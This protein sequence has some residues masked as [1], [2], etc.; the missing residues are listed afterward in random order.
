MK[1]I[2]LSIQEQVYN[3]NLEFKY[4]NNDESEHILQLLARKFNFDLENRWLWDGNL[5]S[6][7]QSYSNDWEYLLKLELS[8]LSDSIFICPSDDEFYPWPL[9]KGPKD[10]VIELL[11]SLYFFEY[12]IFDERM[13]KVLFDTHH[14]T[15][16]V[17]N[18]ENR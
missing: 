15:L 10:Q 5:K 2:K 3:L 9:F 16:V 11:K 6:K 4:I 1:N 7:V 12:F 14:N 8:D 18:I 13:N 17:N